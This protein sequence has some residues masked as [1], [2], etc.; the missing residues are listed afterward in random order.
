MARELL[1]HRLSRSDWLV[2]ASLC[3]VVVVAYIPAMRAGFVWDDSILVQRSDLHKRSG[4]RDIW[5]SLNIEN[6]AHYWPVTYTTLWIEHQLWGLKPLGY[7]L[8]NIGL[9]L[10]NSLLVW[11]LMKRMGVAGAAVIGAVFAAH[12]LHVE[13]V[14][15]IIERKDVLSGLLYLTAVLTWMRFTESPKPWRYALTL[16]LYTAGMLA[17]SVVVTLPAALLIWHW[18][19]RGRITRVDLTRLTP[20]FATG[21]TI[22]LADL[23][24]YSSREPLDLGYSLAE[25]VMIA[26]RALWFYT[27]KLLWPTDLVVIYPHWET[28]PVDPVNLAFILAAVATVAALWLTRHRIGRGPL[29]GTAFFAVTLAPT[30]GFIDYGYMQFSFVADRFQYLAGIGVT[31]VI[32]GAIALGD[33]RYN[34]GGGTTPQKTHDVDSIDPLSVGHT[35]GGGTTPQKT[36]R[37]RHTDTGT[38]DATAEAIL[39]RDATAGMILLRCATAGVILLLGVLSWRHASLYRD[40]VTLFSHIVEHN[41]QAR[42][43]HAN[44]GAGY[45]EAGRYEEGIDVSEIALERTPDD[46]GLYANIALAHM[47]LGRFDLAEDNMRRALEIEPNNAESMFK[48]GNV[49]R[50]AKRHEEAV[51][52]YRAALAADGETPETHAGMGVSLYELDRYEEALKAFG[53]ALALH[54]DIPQVWEVHRFSGLSARALGDW[55]AAVQHHEKAFE[56]DPSHYDVA[57]ELSAMLTA[58]G[59][60]EESDAYLQHARALRPDDGDTMHLF[61][62]SEQLRSQGLHEQAIAT[63]RSVL[64]NSPDHARAHAGLGESLYRKGLHEEAMKTMQRALDLQVE[65]HTERTLHYLI[66]DAAQQSDRVDEAIDHLEAALEIDPDFT[67]ALD[68]LARL[69]FS[70]QDYTEALRNF[71]TLAKIQPDDAGAITNVGVALFHLGRSEEAL[72]RLDEALALDPTYETAIANRHEVIRSMQDAQTEQHP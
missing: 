8:T 55:D 31:A 69:H 48:L 38:R 12:P 14:A 26:A 42:M 64:E 61:T 15:W 66:A 4:L 7:H 34:R 37:P 18:Y 46:A 21:L 29:A 27:G 49:L 45:M 67:E 43:A 54:P 28:S 17:K 36:P 41:P 39:L 32:V 10:I 72:N 24:F 13:S 60:H 68:S 58:L 22:A 57:I 44:L 70:Q 3:A 53:R 47:Q 25:R 9:H 20:F 59:R 33:R 6:E 65:S 11:R 62:L 35:R 23:A 52:Q 1:P 2:A 56:S 30:L 5:F 19:Q 40:Q 50:G 16:A 71:E 63:Y 51:E